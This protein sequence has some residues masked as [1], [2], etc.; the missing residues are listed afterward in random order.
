ME[1]S[2]TAVKLKHSYML[3]RILTDAN[4]L[5]ISEASF[6]KIVISQYLTLQYFKSDTLCF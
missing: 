5:A 1:I 4:I 3:K 6:K 2:L